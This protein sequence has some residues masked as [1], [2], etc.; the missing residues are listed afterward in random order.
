M[1][2]GTENGLNVGGGS[3]PECIQHLKD[4]RTLH[5]TSLQNKP[6]ITR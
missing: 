1:Y 3:V 4:K 6:K 2:V 5:A